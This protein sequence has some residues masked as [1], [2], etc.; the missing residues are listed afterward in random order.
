METWCTKVVA[1][2]MLAE[3]TSIH[4]V[5]ARVAG[6]LRCGVVPAPLSL[7]SSAPSNTPTPRSPTLCLRTPTPQ[8]STLAHTVAAVP[9]LPQT[10]L[11]AWL[12]G[13]WQRPTQS[14]PRWSVFAPAP[15][16]QWTPSSDSAARPTL[17]HCV[18]CLRLAIFPRSA[19]TYSTW[20]HRSTSISS[21]HTVRDLHI[22]PLPFKAGSW[23]P[24]LYS[25]WTFSDPLVL[26][27]HGT[28]HALW[29]TTECLLGSRSVT[30]FRP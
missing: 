19:H 9:A 21:D 8:G 6:R 22:I 27:G 29:P 13:L 26:S 2:P 5:A 4:P 11:S 7:F 1:A 18:S 28:F 25:S 17:S 24:F 15:R 3:S 20:S 10:P 30:R 23:L 14:P 16:W 12:Y